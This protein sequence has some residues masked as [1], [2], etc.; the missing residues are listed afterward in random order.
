MKRTKRLRR[1]V[2]F[3]LP[4]A[5]AGCYTVL[6]HPTDITATSSSSPH[7]GDAE[8]TS[9]CS[10]CHYESEWLGYYDHPLVWGYPAYSGYT[11]W[12]DYYGRPWWYDN[13]W[14]EE[15]SSSGGSSGGRSWWERR[16]QERERTDESG[17]YGIYPGA[18]APSSSGAASGSPSSPS[19]NT[20]KKKA[21]ESS[22]KKKKTR[23]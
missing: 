6:H 21:P 10:E 11:W 8:M 19:S 13:Y 3:L 7:E 12:N 1:A 15:G 4:F 17:N 23:G 22:T 9:P 5:L 16:T 20:E 2:L 14:Y 18:Q